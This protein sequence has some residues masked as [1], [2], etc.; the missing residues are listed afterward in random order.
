MISSSLVKCVRKGKI[1]ILIFIVFLCFREERRLKVWLGSDV[2]NY[3]SPM[4]FYVV[5]LSRPSLFYLFFPSFV[6][7]SPA[8]L[9]VLPSLVML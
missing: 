7:L 3:G 1:L 5:Q 9:F 4:G 2:H 8:S 6:E